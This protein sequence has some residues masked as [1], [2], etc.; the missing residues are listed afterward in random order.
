MRYELETRKHLD[1]FA[2]TPHEGCKALKT[3]ENCLYCNFYKPIKDLELEQERA[4]KRLKSLD[5]ATRL[6]IAEKYDIKGL[7]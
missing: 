4:M 5:K 6:H 3:K 7:I 1:C 2:K